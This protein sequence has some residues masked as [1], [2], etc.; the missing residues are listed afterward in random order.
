MKFCQPFEML[1]GVFIAITAEK[2]MKIQGSRA[3]SVSPS[4]PNVAPQISG[5]SNERSNWD[6]GKGW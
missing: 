6:G 3:S 4:G 5:G 1:G 2:P